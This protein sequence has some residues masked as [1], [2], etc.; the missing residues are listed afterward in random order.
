MLITAGFSPA[1]AS[2]DEYLAFETALIKSQMQIEDALQAV[3]EAGNGP[4]VII[5]DRGTMDARAYLTPEQ[6][7]LLLQENSW[8]NVELRDQ[9]YNM[10]VHLVSAAVGAGSHYTTANN[11]ARYETS[12]QAAALD[13]KLYQAWVGH[14]HLRVVDNS[15]DF[16][17]KAKAVPNPPCTSP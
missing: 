4:A 17:T 16:P 11:A 12:D 6:W 1:G 15:T 13:E 5:C 2:F 14:P 10:V 7:D 3:A 9:R 8:N